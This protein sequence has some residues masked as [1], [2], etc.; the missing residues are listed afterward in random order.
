VIRGDHIP[1]WA[2]E[3]EKMMMMMMIIIII[4]IIN[5]PIQAVLIC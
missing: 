1:R 3:P 5:F 2:A 4:I